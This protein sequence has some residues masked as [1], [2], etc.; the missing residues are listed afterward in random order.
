ML[1]RYDP[2]LQVIPNTKKFILN[3]FNIY[4]NYKL[5]IKLIPHQ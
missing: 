5:K 3:V 4:Q 1:S 2:K